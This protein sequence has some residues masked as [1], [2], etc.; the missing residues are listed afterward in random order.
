[1]QRPAKAAGAAAEEAS[2]RGALLL[3]L[4]A[5]AEGLTNKRQFAAAGAVAPLVALLAGESPDGAENAASALGGLA[6]DPTACAA[7]VQ[8]G[9]PQALRRLRRCRPELEEAA[10]AALSLLGCGQDTAEQEKEQQQYIKSCCRAYRAPGY[11]SMPLHR[12]S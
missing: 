4:L 11:R 6:A 12:A 1:M 10:K 2:E 7:A 8:A 3:R 5:C 9:A